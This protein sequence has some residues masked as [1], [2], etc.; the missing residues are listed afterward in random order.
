MR[1][2]DAFAA[3]CILVAVSGAVSPG[4]ARAAPPT[5]EQEPVT[6][7][8]L[9]ASFS[10]MPGLYAEFREEKQMALLAA[11]L[12]NVGTLHFTKG[13]LARHTTQPHK[14]SLVILENRLEFGDESGQEHLDL[15][16]NPVVRLFVDS[17]VKILAGDRKALDRIYTMGFEAQ[18]RAW[19]L[20]LRPK[21]DP[22]D[23]VIDRL[24]LTGTDLIV[25]RM[26]VVEKGGDQTVTTFSGVDVKRRYSAAEAAKVFRVPGK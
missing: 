2:F 17:F 22:M 5:A 15:D 12:V 26:V 20:V 16:G 13:K 4:V 24:E 1:L 9:L 6:V 19:K 11:P 18:G 3:S 8:G 14:S 25:E 10:K 7:D 21:L 23:K